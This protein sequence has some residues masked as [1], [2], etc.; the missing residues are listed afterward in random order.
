MNDFVHYNML[1]LS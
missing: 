1:I